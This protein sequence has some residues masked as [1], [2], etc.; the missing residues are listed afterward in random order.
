MKFS[1]T[2]AVALAPLALA[3]NVRKDVTPRSLIEGRALALANGMKGH[4]ITARSQTE[5]IVIWVNP[6]GGAQTTAINEQVTVITHPA[7]TGHPAAAPPAHPAPA[8]PPAHEAPPAA[9]PAH[10]A[11]PAHE[12]PPAAAPPAHEA[13]AAAPP[14]HEAPP[15]AHPTAEAPPTTTE[16]VAAATHTVKVGGPGGLTFQPDQLQGVPVGDM[17]VFEFLSQNHTVTQSPFDTPCDA[18]DGGM[19]SG[20]QA[21]PNN[22]VVP[23]PQVAMQVMTDKPL[24]FYCKQGNHCGTGMVF[25]INPTAAKT[26]AMFQALA[27]KQKGTG[28]ETPITGG[29]PITPPEGGA[30]APPA[31]PPAAAPPAA[32]P[33]VVPGQGVIEGGACKC[34]VQC[35]AGS[36]AAPNQGLGAVGGVGGSMPMNAMRL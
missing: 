15:A 25:S 24:W 33:G 10:P 34:V 27:I 13:P 6:G 9:A 36:F 31:A 12:A 2:L 19:D 30:A 3:R 5:V 16:H 17:V 35:N 26:Q 32:A 8:A 20:F 1:S 22:T 7:A 11:P 29:A 14:A 4:G 28:K 23:A 21:N 18:M